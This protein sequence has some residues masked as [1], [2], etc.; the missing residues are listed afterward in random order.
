MKTCKKCNIEKDLSEFHKDKIQKDGHRNICI[1]CAKQI[2]TSYYKSN[3]D[4]QMIKKRKNW[5]KFYNSHKQNILKY[6]E[7]YRKENK[8]KRKETSSK[9]KKSE[10]GKISNRIFNHKRRSQI[11][12]SDITS[13]WLLSF[14]KLATH[15]SL[16]QSELNDIQYNPQSK[17]LDHIIPL[18]QGGKHMMN[19]V[20]YICQTCNLSR[21][22]NGSDL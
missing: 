17:H 21:P 15:C 16:C 1:L 8:L 4:V 3:R 10:K 9:Y 5:S 6:Q 13:N 7:K 2:S 14:T 20:R 19:N 11:K 12:N 22:K 18:N